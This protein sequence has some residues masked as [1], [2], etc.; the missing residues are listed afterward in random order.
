VRA[1]FAAFYLPLMLYLPVPLSRMV[2]EG[3]PRFPPAVWATAAYVWF[4]I[5]LNASIAVVVTVLVW[6]GARR[7]VARRPMSTMAP[8]PAAV[9]KG[10][11]GL[12]RLTDVAAGP[13]LTRRQALGW[14]AAALPPVATVGL[15]AVAM[16][17]RGSFRVRR[18]DLPIPGLPPDLDGLTIAHVTDLHVGNFVPANA[19]SPA[20]RRGERAASRL[21][22]LHRR[23]DRPRVAGPA[24]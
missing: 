12:P 19:L 22:R 24:P 1:A 23:P 17:Q 7:I 11:E 21:G 10:G 20:G 18:L 3:E 16:S 2:L 9:I 5:V 8:V 13:P 6:R 15:T 14:A 4:P